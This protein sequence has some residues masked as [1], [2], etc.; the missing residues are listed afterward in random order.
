MTNRYE[1]VNRM[2][3]NIE[4]DRFYGTLSFQYRNGVLQTVKKEEIMMG[5]NIIPKAKKPH[6]GK[7]AEEVNYE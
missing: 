6:S 7:T 3:D 5:K 4:R 2:L 1:T